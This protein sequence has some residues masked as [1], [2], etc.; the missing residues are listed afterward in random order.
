MD[1]TEVYRAK[2]ACFSPDGLRV[3]AVADNR[4]VVRQADT[5]QITH[6][7]VVGDSSPT[8]SSGGATAGAGPSKSSGSRTGAS[9][10]DSIQAA[11]S[12]DSR[13]ILAALPT[14]SPSKSGP[15]SSCSANAVANAGIVQVF[16]VRDK[17]W[18]A[19][20]NIGIE[21]LSK[22]VWAPD[23]RS[24]LCFSEWGVSARSSVL[25]RDETPRRDALIEHV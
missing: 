23:A 6:T 13:Y 3:L 24:I 5:F 22:A 15:S 9:T 1:F 8:S 21:G 12:C 14:T 19:T 18:T 11:W 2:S 10:S 20:I 4:V 16:D 17:A 25:F 7:W